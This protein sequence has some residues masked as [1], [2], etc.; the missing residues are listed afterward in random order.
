MSAFDTALA[1][2]YET[3]HLE[4]PAEIQGCFCCLDAAEREVLLTRPLGVLTSRQL[5]PYASSVFLTLG[6]VS[7][8]RYFLPRI[9]D[10][11]ASD[12]GWWPSPELA[13]GAL[14]R[15]N[16]DTWPDGEREAIEAF[17]RAWLDRWASQ[18]LNDTRWNEIDALLCGIARAGLDV[19]P[20][21]ERLLAPENL[22][23]LRELNA[24]NGAKAENGGGAKNFW[25]EAPEGWRRLSAFLTSMAVRERLSADP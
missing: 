16:W 19:Q 5:G 18:R 3:F 22:D 4:R 12:L 23:G 8:Y 9:L 21:F 6:H 2:L 25:E 13:V 24:L 10:I 7:D 17:L 1:G 15:A 11:S 20:Y 14:A